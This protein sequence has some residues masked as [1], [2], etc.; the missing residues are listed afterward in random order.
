MIASLDGNFDINQ[1]LLHSGA[2]VDLRSNNGE[3]ALTVA[4]SHGRISRTRT[5]KPLFVLH[6]T[7][8]SSKLCTYRSS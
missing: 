1:L 4:S 3:T 6:K 5:E 2:V 8:G 7:M